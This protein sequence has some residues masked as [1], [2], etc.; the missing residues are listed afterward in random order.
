M[1]KYG[2]LLAIW[3]AT[4]G[5]FW[6]GSTSP[7]CTPDTTREDLQTEFTAYRVCMESAGTTRCTMTPQD[8]VR[9]YKIKRTLEIRRDEPTDE[10]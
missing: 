2:I 3:L 7:I 8:F 6:F 5:G 1:N 9:Y 10:K 4:I